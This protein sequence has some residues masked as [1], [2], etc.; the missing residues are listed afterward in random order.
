[1]KSLYPRVGALPLAAAFSWVVMSTATAAEADVTEGLRHCASFPSPDERLACFDTLASRNGAREVQPE[2]VGVLEPEPASSPSRIASAWDPGSVEQKGRFALVVY[3]PNYLLAGTWNFKPNQKPF[4]AEGVRVPNEEVKLQ[5]SFRVKL[6]EGL[7][8]DNGDL[9]A[10]YT[11]QSYW[12]AYSKSAPFR[13]TAYEP[14]LIFNWRTNFDFFGMQA[15]L[16]SLELNHQSN[17]R[18]EES[19]LSRSW[20]RVIGK[21]AV[22]RGNFVAEARAWWRIPDPEGDDDN[23][24][25]EHYLGNSE[26]LLSW[27]RGPHT[28]S[29]Q[30]RSNFTPSRH[31]GAA[32]LSW[33]FPLPGADNLKGYLQYFYGYGETLIDYN[34]KTHRV[35]VGVTVADWY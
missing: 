23:P 25:I 33:S 24:D 2:N 3:K 26:F 12:Q 21:L 6:A 29:A 20:N 9:W 18:D 11:Q 34:A 16:L 19:A 1:M 27:E 17:G 28:L 4:A 32:E 14:S 10:T 8:G 22:E 35:G 15:R 5:L 31:R 30:L 13:D 7:I